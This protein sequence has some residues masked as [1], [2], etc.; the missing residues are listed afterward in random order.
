MKNEIDNK[1]QDVGNANSP[2]PYAGDATSHTAYMIMRHIKYSEF[3]V[4]FQGKSIAYLGL[5]SCI[6]R[7]VG[8]KNPAPLS[9]CLSRRLAEG[10]KNIPP[11]LNCSRQNKHLFIT[12]R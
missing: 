4:L 6:L 7:G 5:W 3:P 2:H 9:Y 1:R 10:I 8:K 12:G 11:L